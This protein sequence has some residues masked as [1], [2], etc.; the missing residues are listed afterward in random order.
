M[1][2]QATR[3]GK[4]T[5]CHVGSGSAYQRVIIELIFQPPPLS[6]NVNGAKLIRMETR[7]LRITRRL[8]CAGQSAPGAACEAAHATAAP[9]ASKTA[10]AGNTSRFF[11]TTSQKTAFNAA[12]ITVRVKGFAL[13]VRK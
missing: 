2:A 8:A 13:L 9:T 10:S 12:F 5:I 3:R 1:K 11:Q 6:I 4:N 7:K